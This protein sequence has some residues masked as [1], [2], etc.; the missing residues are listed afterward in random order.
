MADK[1]PVLIVI[2]GPNGSGKT[3]ITEQLLAHEWGEDCC[4]IN[5]DLIARDKFGD[6]NSDEAVLKAARYATELRYDLLSRREN[7][8]F[9]TVLSSDEKIEY[10]RQAKQAGYFVRVFFVS[11]ASPS[12][13]AARITSRYIKGGHSVPIDKI[14]S[15]YTKS[16]VNCSRIV[17]L[18]DRV[19]LFDNTAENATAVLLFRTADGT[20]ARQYVADIPRWAAGIFS[21]AVRKDAR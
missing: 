7:L 1:Q 8:V 2:A 21:Q 17:S 12:I 14:V 19:Y 6:W 13:N 4:Y 9:E 15:R 20:L 10:I 16:I 18:A 5:P 11:T 3:T